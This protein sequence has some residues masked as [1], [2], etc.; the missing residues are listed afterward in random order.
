MTTPGDLTGLWAETQVTAL[1][2]A[3][4]PDAPDYGSEAWL[5]LRTEDPR[6]AAAILTAAE[7]WRRHRE[8]ED[9]LERLLEDDPEEWFRLVTRDA[10]R[11]AARMGRDMAEQL[12]QV[13]RAT[14]ARTTHQTPRAVVATADWPPVQIPGRPG[15]YRHCGPG[16]EQTD[17]PHNDRSGAPTA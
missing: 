13:Q 9:Y 12:E 4:Q 6:R 5:R 14:R 17:L 11:H 8:Y 7:Q 2:S 10:D 15:W 3:D 1:L 16:G